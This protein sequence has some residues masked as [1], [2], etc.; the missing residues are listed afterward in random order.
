MRTDVYNKFTSFFK[1]YPNFLTT[2][3]RHIFEAELTAT[4]PVPVD[5][6][7]LYAFTPIE[8]EQSCDLQL[9]LKR[10]FDLTDIAREEQQWRVNEQSVLA[11]W[12]KNAK[13]FEPRQ[14]SPEWQRCGQ[15]CQDGRNRYA[16]LARSD[17]GDVTFGARHCPRCHNPSIS[18]SYAL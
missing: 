15:V 11:A 17:V 6:I 18:S 4:G 14:A 2:P 12:L 1:V 7:I 13:N 10:L 8:N 9:F 5:K 16:A 3:H